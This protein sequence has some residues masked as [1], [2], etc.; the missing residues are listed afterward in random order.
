MR[1]HLLDEDTAYDIWRQ[2]QV[3]E[4]MD[5]PAIEFD[6]ASHTYRLDGAVVPSVTQLLEPVRRELGGSESVLEYKRQIGKALDKT[7]ELS[8]RNDLDYSS[9]DE[10]VLPFFEAWLQFK[11]DSEFR[12]LLNQP[13]VYSR[14]LRFAGTL[15]ILG[16]RHYTSSVPDEL[17]DTKCVWTIDP[18][19]A[20][21]TAGYALGAR[22]SL[23]INVKKR[24][25]L[26]LLRDGKY[27]L[28]PYT[29]PADESVFKSCLTIHAWKGLHK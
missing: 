4:E 26:Q 11:K 3:D 2:R 15:D 5:R 13:V 29:N 19:T 20:I 24:G 1:L 22:E 8:E 14:K 28:F 10:A 12:V 25:G 9:I 7:I 23:G 6:E 27:K 17:L 16:T 18:A 21:Q